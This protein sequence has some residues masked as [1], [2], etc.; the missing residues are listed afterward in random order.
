M[1]DDRA[2]K[3]IRRHY[4]ADASLAQIAIELDYSRSLVKTIHQSALFY[5]AGCM[6]TSHKEN[7]FCEI[8]E[9]TYQML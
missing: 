2:F 4:V 9:L 1:H 5:L 6:D 3:V 8:G 7:A